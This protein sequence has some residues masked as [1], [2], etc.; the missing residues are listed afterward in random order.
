MGLVI[1]QQLIKELFTNLTNSLLNSILINVS[2]LVSGFHAATSWT[3]QTLAKIPMA[4]ALSANGFCTFCHSNFVKFIIFFSEIYEG[5]QFSV[6]SQ[7]QLWYRNYSQKRKTNWKKF[8][9]SPPTHSQ[10][11][12]PSVPDS[13][14]CSIYLKIF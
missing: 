8:N 9:Y 14:E 3:L 11:S 5:K 12:S 7:S 13:S 6:S 1:K 2:A 10:Q 4:F